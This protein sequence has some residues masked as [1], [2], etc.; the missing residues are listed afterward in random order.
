M[1]HQDKQSTTPQFS[2]CINHVLATPNPILL[3][4]TYRS[5]DTLPTINDLVLMST[6]KDRSVSLDSP[7]YPK[8]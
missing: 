8:V 1:Y 5:A 7:L 4:R 6:E 3:I 2:S